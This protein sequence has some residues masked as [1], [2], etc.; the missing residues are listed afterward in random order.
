MEAS[1]RATPRFAPFFIW[2]GGCAGAGPLPP[3]AMAMRAGKAC[4]AAITAAL[5]AFVIISPA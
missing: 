3:C 5:H 4:R 1:G 2:E